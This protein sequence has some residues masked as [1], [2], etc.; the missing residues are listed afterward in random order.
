MTTIRRATQN[1][2]PALTEMRLA[3]Q[4]HDEAHNPRIWHTTPEGKRRHTEQIATMLQDP[5]G[6]TLIAEENGEPTGFAWATA[7]TRPHYTPERVATIN[8][9]YVR[10]GHRRRGTGTRLVRA[11]CDHLAAQRVQEVTLNYIIGNPHAEHFWKKL[12]LI[13]VRVSV[14]TPLQQLQRRL[15]TNPQNP[16]NPKLPNKPKKG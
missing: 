7:T 5:D 15:N 8:L 2:T 4:A 13:P 16:S 3:L 11:L 12:G 10:E 1:D 9:I 14:N 6:V